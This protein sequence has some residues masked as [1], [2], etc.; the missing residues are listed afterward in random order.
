MGEVKCPRCGRGNKTD[1]LNCR[2]CGLQ[3]REASPAV[4]E[5][6]EMNT[7]AEAEAMWAP[8]PKKSHKG[9]ILGIVAGAVVVAAAAV[10]AVILLGGNKTLGVTPDEIEGWFRD[11]AEEGNSDA[12]FL[13]EIW[14]LL[15]DAPE[16]KYTSTSD[17]K[18]ERFNFDSMGLSVVGYCDAKDHEISQMIVSGDLYGLYSILD[19]GNSYSTI[20]SITEV[21]ESALFELVAQEA[22]GLSEEKAEEVVDES[23]DGEA[24]VK[25]GTTWYVKGYHND[26]DLVL[27]ISTFEETDAL[28]D[29]MKE[30]E[31]EIE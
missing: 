8:A 29:Y 31:G 22:L 20:C 28:M 19:E 16:V 9:L 21:T 3:L 12:E 18:I 7:G 10:T 6:L 26:E 1:A 5:G 25:N 4:Q 11:A 2:E 23:G 27:M 30:L 13:I 14:E 17:K 24:V 15:E